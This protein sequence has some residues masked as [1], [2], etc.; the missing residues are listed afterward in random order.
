M[1]Q[2]TDWRREW[3]C[4]N[5][6]PDFII[7][8]ASARCGGKGHG[9]SPTTCRDFLKEPEVQARIAEIQRERFEK[10]ELAS[11]DL[12]RQVKAGATADIADY[13]RVVRYRGGVKLSDEV[14][15]ETGEYAVPSKDGDEEDV[16][17]IP[18]HELSESARMAIVGVKLDR[19]GRMTYV[20]A[21][22]AM[23]QLGMRHL[24]M[25][26]DNTTHSFDFSNLTDE[27]LQA[28]H[29]ILKSAV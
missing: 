13:Y 11:D 18:P 17:L 26:K 16:E 5:Y 8:R 12:L 28:I 27:Q 15:P 10:A 2:L 23:I 22:E 24:G 19:Q 4:R 3:F 14:D 25:L 1:P 20:L 21:K 29:G 9:F 7:N 6:G